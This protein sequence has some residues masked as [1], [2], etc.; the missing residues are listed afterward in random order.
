MLREFRAKYATR[1]IE[2][3]RKL[4][5]KYPE[6]RDRIENIIDLLMVKLERLRRYD[7]ADYLFTLYHAVKEFPE[8]E[9]IIPPSEE[10]ES[11]LNKESQVE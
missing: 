9:E 10:I 5:E 1:L 2:I 7:L 8:L 4:I 11:L 3:K 6:K